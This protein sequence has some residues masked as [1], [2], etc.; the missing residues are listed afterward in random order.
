VLLN[1]SNLHHG[2]GVQVASSVCEE[3]CLDPAGH[4]WSFV[5]S[6]RV[7]ENLRPE[8]CRGMA[9]EIV[10]MRPRRL[11]GGAPR[12]LREIEARVAPDVCCTVFGPPYWSPRSPHLCGFADGWFTFRGGAAWRTL[13]LLARARMWIT[14]EVKRRGL[15]SRWQY[16]VET[17]AARQALATEI[18][19]GPER[20]HHVPNAVHRCFLEH[21]RT[22]CPREPTSQGAGFRILCPSAYYPHKNLESIPRVAA[23]LAARGLREF[24]FVL[25]LPVQSMA[26]ERIARAARAL[27]MEGHVRTVGV[28]PIER[29]PALYAS[30]HCVFSPSVLETF[31]G[32]YA[33][34]IIMGRP[35]VAV[36]LPAARQLYGDAALVFPPFDDVGAA[37]LL[38]RL[39]RESDFYGSAVARLSA[40]VPLVETGQRRYR[41]IVKI[42][43][44]MVRSRRAADAPDDAERTAAQRPGGSG[45][46]MLVER[47]LA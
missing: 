2:G 28:Q 23:A 38:Y 18:K 14:L 25:T 41:R 3:A 43:E 35:L 9:V 32:N 4:Q 31:S 5:V 33:E 12:T 26:W 17:E 11:G 34:S 8:V 36:D 37:A 1:A 15:S 40:L 29:C 30:A 22:R 21:R 24:E 27:G 44:S 45:Q 19:C 16:M 13:G 39:A 7:A 46:H 42:L 20:V 10:D 47:G 6:T